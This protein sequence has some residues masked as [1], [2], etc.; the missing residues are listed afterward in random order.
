MLADHPSVDSLAYPVN[1][2]PFSMVGNVLDGIDLMD[3][4]ENGM[5]D[6][7]DPTDWGYPLQ[8]AGT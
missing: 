6:Y 3:F 8:G 7:R 2:I 5:M 1:D 4:F